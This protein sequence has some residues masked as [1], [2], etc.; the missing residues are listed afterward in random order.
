M[1]GNGFYK[2][3]AIC[4]EEFW[5]VPARLRRGGGKYCSRK[6][7]HQGQRDQIGGHGIRWK[8]GRHKRH[9]YV[10]L[11][12][13]LL[14]PIEFKLFAPMFSAH[15]NRYVQEHRLVMAQHLGRPLESWEI[16]HHKNGIKDDN[17]IE[18][19]ELLPR[20]ADHLVRQKIEAENRKW[21]RAFYHAIAMWLREK[22]GTKCFPNLA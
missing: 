15:Q 21:E 20:P 11:H 7:Q 3:C 9:G 5:V 10:F 1:R 6:C 22:E 16:V 4:G 14:L 19:L 18:N 2:S 17:R 12:K 13:S 8:G